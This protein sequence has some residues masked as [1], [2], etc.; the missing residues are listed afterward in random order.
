MRFISVSEEFFPEL[1]TLQLAYKEEIGEEAP[2][3]A[4]RLHLEEALRQKSILFYGAVAESSLV[5]VCSVCRIF[6]TFNYRAGGVF[7]DFYIRPAYRHQ[8]IAR[9]LAAFAWHESGVSSLTVGCAPVTRECI[10]PLVFACLW[11]PFWPTSRRKQK[12]RPLLSF[13]SLSM[14]R[15]HKKSSQRGAFL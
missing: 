1:W 11:V 7:E 4:D 3:E 5:A 6:S 10:A 2:C 9:Q 15:A 8:G 14:P 12:A 13:Q